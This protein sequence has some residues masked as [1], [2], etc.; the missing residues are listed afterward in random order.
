VG[1]A[2]DCFV[3]FSGEERDE[4][5]SR[6]HCRL[7][8]NPPS[9]RVRDLGSTNG[10]Y[11]NGRELELDDLSATRDWALDHGDL[12]TIGGTTLRVDILDCP[13]AGKEADASTLWN[14]G[15]IAKKDCPVPC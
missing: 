3:Q 14:P 13:H 5:I 7:D 10:T 8:I 12:I 6:H 4:L 11:V 9:I 1:R 2:L 15:E